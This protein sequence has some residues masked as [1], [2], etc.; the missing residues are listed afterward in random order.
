M[1]DG[2]DMMLFGDDDIDVLGLEHNSSKVKKGDMFFCLKGTTSDGH[3]FVYEAIKNGARAIVSEKRIETPKNVANIVVGNT[4]RAMSEMA[5]E[6][7]SNPSK[8]MLV[9]SITGT[10]GKTTTSYMLASIFE[11]ARKKVGV[12]GTNGVLVGGKKIETAMTTPDPIE[13]Q[14]IFAYMREKGVEVIV[15][16]MSAHALFYQKNWGVM[17]DIS[18]FTNLSEDHLDFFANMEKYGKAKKMLFSSKASK[19]AVINM[20]DSFAQSIIKDIDIPYLTVSKQATADCFATSIIN[21]FSNQTFDACGK[22]WKIKVNIN[23]GGLFNISNALCAIGAARLCGISNQDIVLGLSN[24][25]SVPGRFN[26]KFARGKK[27]I[28]DYAHTP[29]GLENILK[30]CRELLSNKESKLISVFGCGGNRDAL[31]RPIMGDISTRLA[32][33][34][35]IT[36]D[37]PR[38]ENPQEIIEEIE[39]GVTTEAVYY[40]EVDRVKAIQ[41]AEKLAGSEDIIVISGKGIENYMDIGGKKIPYSDQSVID[42]LGG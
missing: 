27:F 6:F 14:K 25:Q 19:V 17:S 40:K 11:A 23:M 8:D 38:L 32:D 4:R 1:I 20:D 7:Y 16:E 37:N 21:N 31:K 30:A 35:I 2:K 42:E 24:L 39:S 34:T 3:N 15:M 28:I 5:S 36:S 12:I 29:D 41:L 9:V 22:D 13:L 18:I 10:N 26:I 33:V